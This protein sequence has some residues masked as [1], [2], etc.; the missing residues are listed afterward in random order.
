MVGM[1]PFYRAA[2]ATHEVRLVG[3]LK[4]ATQVLKVAS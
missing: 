1:L 4:D 3:V 2:L